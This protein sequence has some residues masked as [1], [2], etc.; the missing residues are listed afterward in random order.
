MCASYLHEEA[1]GRAGVVQEGHHAR[2]AH[3]LLP[4]PSPGRLVGGTLQ[5]V[6]CLAQVVVQILRHKHLQQVALAYRC[7][8]QDTHSASLRHQTV[9]FWK[10]IEERPNQ[11]HACPM[12]ML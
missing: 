4:G 1:G 9:P 12:K 3:L 5:Q 10:G 6:C 8:E 2:P 7:G 11:E